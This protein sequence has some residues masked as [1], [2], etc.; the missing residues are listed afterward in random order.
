MY[1]VYIPFSPST[2]KFYVGQTED[3]QKRIE[4]H[5]KGLVSST[6]KGAPWNVIKAIEC[7]SRSEAVL[8]ETKIKKRGI[9]RFL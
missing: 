4:R 8:L 5:N 9:K 2:Q 1:F 6:K 3:L 7:P